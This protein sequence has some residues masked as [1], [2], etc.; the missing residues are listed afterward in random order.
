MS[1]LSSIGSMPQ[2]VWYLVEVEKETAVI[3]QGQA[4]ADA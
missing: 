2:Q 4:S 3:P 1:F